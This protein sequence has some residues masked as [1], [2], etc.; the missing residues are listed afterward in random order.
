MLPERNALGKSGL[1]V[2]RLGLGTAPL[3]NMYAPVSDENANATFAAAIAAGINLI[4][5]APLY[6]AGLAEQRVGIGLADVPREQYLLSSKVGRLIADDGTVSFDWSRDGIL[7]SVEASLQRLNLDSIDILLAHDP[8][9]HEEA[10][11]ATGFPTMLELREQGVVKAIG[12]GM[13]QWQMLDRFLDRFDLNVVL[14]AGRYT[15]LE[16]GA[17]SF[18]DRCQA[19]G[20]GVMLGGVFNS[21]ILATGARPGAKYN[22]ADAPPEIMARVQQLEAICAR[23][24]VPLRQAA[25]QFVLRN[26]A[27]S[28]VV[29]GAVTAAEVQDNIATLQASIPDTLWEELAI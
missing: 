9:D 4:D 26:P 21:G 19:Q 28:S 11:I 22:Y 17:A 14:L 20:V 16:Q 8:D 6:G 7:R 18:L 15:L 24:G 10:A 29:F 3:A 13:N 23:H 12:S 2:S 25:L 27:V 1:M 5:T